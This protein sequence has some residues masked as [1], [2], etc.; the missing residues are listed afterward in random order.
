[1]AD[2]QT[3]L[4]LDDELDLLIADGASQPV[5]VWRKPLKR[6]QTSL[7]SSDLAAVYIDGDVAEGTRRSG[8]VTATCLDTPCWFK[9][10]RRADLEQW[11]RC[12]LVRPPGNRTDHLVV[13]CG[14]KLKRA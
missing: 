14:N 5:E 6:L 2:L 12:R 13:N 7:G 10:G 11:G 4:G 9:V 3:L 1:M 8:E